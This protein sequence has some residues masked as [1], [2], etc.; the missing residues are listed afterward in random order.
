MKIANYEIN[1]DVIVLLEWW[2]RRQAAVADRTGAS[3]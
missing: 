2:G 3:G 1:K